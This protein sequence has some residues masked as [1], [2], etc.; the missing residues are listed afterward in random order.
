MFSYY[1]GFFFFITIV[2]M[3]F[4]AVVLILFYIYT[5]IKDIKDSI[6]QFKKELKQ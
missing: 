5:A 4:C 2:V 3:L 6:K 1:F